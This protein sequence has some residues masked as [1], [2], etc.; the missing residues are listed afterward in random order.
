VASPGRKN[1]P[2]ASAMTSVW[3]MMMHDSFLLLPTSVMKQAGHERTNVPHEKGIDLLRHGS[4]GSSLQGCFEREQHDVDGEYQA[5]QRPHQDPEQ[6]HPHET[7]KES[8]SFGGGRWHQHVR[9][10]RGSLR[11]GDAEEGR[12]EDEVLLRPSS[13]EAPAMGIP[14]HRT[15]H[16]NCTI[17]IVRGNFHAVLSKTH[18]RQTLRFRPSS[19]RRTA[20]HVGLDV[21]PRLS[22]SN[23]LRTRLPSP[24]VSGGWAKGQKGFVKERSDARRATYLSACRNG[25]WRRLWKEEDW[26]VSRRRL[27]LA[28]D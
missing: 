13:P 3:K 14:A 9:I 8:S 17:S 4:H 28:S 11:H 7:V 12:E 19:V 15:R 6:K 20:A 27:S 23:F 24:K 16:K 25:A 5:R 22:I 2:E 10:V 1:H 21:T 26:T 18:L